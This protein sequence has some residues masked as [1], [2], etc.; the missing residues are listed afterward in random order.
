MVHLPLW[1]RRFHS[2]RSVVSRWRAGRAE[3]RAA[4]EWAAARAAAGLHSGP[5]SGGS[6]NLCLRTLPDPVDRRFFCTKV[7]SL[8]EMII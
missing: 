8:Q 7:L 2:D 5:R 4:L 1:C 6:A 3:A